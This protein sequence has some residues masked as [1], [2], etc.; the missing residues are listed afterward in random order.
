MAYTYPF[1]F[2]R[3]SVL[4]IPWRLTHLLL[5]PDYFKTRP[6]ILNSATS[7]PY[8]ASS[9]LL[10]HYF[11]FSIDYLSTILHI[12]IYTTRPNNNTQGSS[13][14]HKRRES[15][16]FSYY[17]KTVSMESPFEK[18]ERHD[19]HAH[20]DETSHEKLVLPKRTQN[21]GPLL[22]IDSGK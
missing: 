22:K 3:Y 19:D 14:R 10:F 16:K 5:S 6:L 15:T 12:Y 4:A 18:I 2:F 1:K 17:E 13:M 11:S 20:I 9:V 8:S 7:F 21:L